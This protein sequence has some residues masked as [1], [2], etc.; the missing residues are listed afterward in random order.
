MPAIKQPVVVTRR[1]NGY[2]LCMIKDA[3]DNL[4]SLVKITTLFS[5]MYHI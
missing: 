2:F 1:V 4:D 5:S 3:R